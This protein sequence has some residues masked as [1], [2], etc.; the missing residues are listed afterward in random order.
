MAVGDAYIKAPESIAN[1]AHLDLQPGA[2]V[3]IVVHNI[4]VPV[5]SAVE[6]YYFDGTDTIKFDEDPVD[7]SRYNQ[8]FHCTNS[9]YVR[10]K[11]V[12]GAALILGADGMVTK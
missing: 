5:G 6:L 11:N 2:G 9:V 3:E 1:A 4:Y 7:G 10:V 12:S 8:Q